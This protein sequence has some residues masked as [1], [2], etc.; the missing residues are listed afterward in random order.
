MEVDKR[1]LGFAGPTSSMHYIMRM[2]EKL[3]DT[4][5]PRAAVRPTAPKAALD[6]PKAT[7]KSAPPRNSRRDRTSSR[8]PSSPSTRGY[9]R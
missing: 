4:A 1:I 7:R 3:V 2:D 9:R 6:A 5:P 8:S